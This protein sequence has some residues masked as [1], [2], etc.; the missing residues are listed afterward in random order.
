MINT[1][2]YIHIENKK[3]LLVKPIKHNVFYMIGG[4]PEIDEEESIALIREVEE[5]LSLK[6]IDSSLSFFDKFEGQA[7][8]KP[9]GT[10][11]NISCYIGIHEGVIK[12]K[13][14]IETYKYFT[15][16][17]YINMDEQAPVVMLILDNL[18]AKGLI[19]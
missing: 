7:Y 2:A 15:Y 5:E 3:L 10:L 4:K 17:E 6:L 19:I 9:D 14:E 8:G 18:K 16:N 1:V 12:V 13:N 11:V